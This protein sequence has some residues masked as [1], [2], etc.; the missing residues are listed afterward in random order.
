MHEYVLNPG[1]ETVI[2]YYFYGMIPGNYKGALYLFSN[3]PINPV[4]VVS[5]KRP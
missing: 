2:N 4:L 1:S 3:D 5:V